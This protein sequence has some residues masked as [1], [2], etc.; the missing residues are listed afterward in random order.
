MTAGEGNGLR[1]TEALCVIIENFEKAKL[2][3]NTY[4]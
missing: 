3:A 1:C 4:W 2:K